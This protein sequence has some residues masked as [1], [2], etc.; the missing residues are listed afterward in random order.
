[1]CLR[2]IRSFRKSCIIGLNSRSARSAE[3]S[4]VEFVAG[5]QYGFP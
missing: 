3:R 4:D 2:H 1:M 5:V